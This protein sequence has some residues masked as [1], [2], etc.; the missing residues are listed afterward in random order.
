VHDITREGA[1][2]RMLRALEEFVIEGPTTLLGFHR[3]LLDSPCFIA[4]ETCLGLVESAEL[5]ERAQSIGA[6][7]PYTVTKVPSSSDGA[8]RATRLEVVTV[9]VDGRRHEVRVQASAPPWA[10][11]GRRH[12]SRSK[13]LSAGE[14][15][16]VISPMQG[17]V[18]EIPVADG[19]AVE[20][21]SVICVVEAMKMENE[22]V[23]HRTGVVAALGV[24][25]GQQVA[26][27]QLICVLEPA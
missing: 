18:L 17:V 21:G 15:G 22:I 16:A 1:R 19:D 20:P 7:S 3:A 12:K 13:G 25:V 5:A 11:L 24:T 26:S 27:G 4:G 23:A 14:S 2:R 6:R 10:E 9:E 8:S